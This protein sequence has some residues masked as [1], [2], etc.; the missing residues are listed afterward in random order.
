MVSE[1]DQEPPPLPVGDEVP[2]PSPDAEAIP[3]P[4]PMVG[5]TEPE[6]LEPPAATA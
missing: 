4:E 2:E 3:A 5:E 1:Q 6:E